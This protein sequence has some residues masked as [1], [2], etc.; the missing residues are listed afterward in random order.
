[1]AKR[2]GYIIEQIADMDN[3]RC[4]DREAQQGK[5]QKNRFIRRHNERA[6]ENL[7][8]LREMIL[9]LDFPNPNHTSMIIETDAGKKRNIVKQPYYPWRILHHAIMR[10]LEPDLYK[11]Y[12]HDTSAC[13]KG[14]GLHYG[15]KRM[16]MF[17]RRYPQYTWFFKTDYKS[18]YESIPHEVIINS[19][20]RKYKDEHFVKL[21]E[22]AILT[23]DSGQE[24]I[25]KLYN[26]K[27]K[28]RANRLL[29]QSATG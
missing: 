9:N 1:M 15:V 20:R 17:M 23:Y 10:V 27:E 11:N 14:R 6:E 19:L 8:K 12:I 16:K 4:A 13:I 28:R 7:L 29:Y 24:T 25:D 26:E 18:F 21:I 3:L 2:K 22:I 5:V